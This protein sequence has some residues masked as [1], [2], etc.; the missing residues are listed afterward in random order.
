MRNITFTSLLLGS[1]L[2]G[3]SQTEELRYHKGI[4]KRLGKDDN[5]QYTIHVKYGSYVSFD[6]MQKGVDLAVD[7]YTPSGAKL[8]TFDSPNGSQGREVISFDART[9]GYYKISI[10]PLSQPDIPDSMRQKYKENNQGSYA[11]QNI[12]V[13]SYSQR[14]K[15]LAG[16]KQQQQQFVDWLTTNA[17]PLKSVIAESG[18]EDLQWL[19]P[20]LQNVK[21]VGLGEATHG[22]REFFQM[23]HRMLEFLVKEMGFTFFSIEASYSG[24]KNINDY[25][26]HG[27]G[28]AQKALASQGFWTWDTEEVISMIEWIRSYNQTVPEHKKVQFYGFDIQINGKGGGVAK[29][30]NYLNKVDTTLT[31]A[32]E[33]F[34]WQLYRADHG[35]KGDTAK[36]IK[37]KHLA[38]LD[39]M[40]LKKTPYIL[41]S[42]KEDYEDALKYAKVIA[43]YLD[44]YIMDAH[45]PRK[46]EREWRD[47]YMATNFFDL[48]QKYPDAKVVIWAHNGHI[49]KDANTYVNGGVKPFGSYLKETY[50][51]AYYA[52]KFAFSKGAFQ[53]INREKGLQE[54][55]VPAAQKKSLDWY[56]ASAKTDKYIIDF[57]QKDL[58]LYVQNIMSAGLRSRTYG[59]SAHPKT[60]NSDY[61]SYVPTYI[62][63]EFDAIIFI[64]NTTRAR[65]TSTGVR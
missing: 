26:L 7:V 17:H 53:A 57:S 47:Y 33:L 14:K 23:K 27:K 58:P 63:K 61:V 19:K 24:C 51:N 38:L 65:P 45:D 18:F 62:P 2:S 3:F 32:H 31:R 25:V 20:I 50:G 49:N 12:D 60:V 35:P 59:A 39:T 28:D 9:Q 52:M 42:S 8:Q 36:M 46:K 44:A 48:I 34:F 64:D 30:R 10:Y 1:V 15:I 37:Q 29:L 41:S 56:L 11:I 43:Q 16:E 55:V 40:I 21:Y 13:L 6:V 22:T 54:F 5:H 4:D